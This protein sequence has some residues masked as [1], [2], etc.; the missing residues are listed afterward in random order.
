M[1]EIKTISEKF[2]NHL[3]VNK[4]SIESVANFMLCS[5]QHLRYVLKGI[6]PLTEAMR[7]KL[8]THL[9]TD[10]KETDTP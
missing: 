4:I 2:Y 9:N 10:F 5:R 8:N 1:T 6:R 3:K 7:V